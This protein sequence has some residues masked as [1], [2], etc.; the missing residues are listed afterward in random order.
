[1]KIL[2]IGG[3]ATGSILLS[4]LIPYMTNHALTL[5]DGDY[6]EEKNLLNQKYTAKDVGKNKAEV[7][8]SKYKKFY[9]EKDITFIPEYLTSLDQMKKI[10]PDIIIGC[11]DNV[12]TRK[13][14]HEYFMERSGNIVYID[15]G[16]GDIERNGQVVT[17]IKVNGAVLKPPVLDV[18]PEMRAIDDQI[19]LPSCE[20][21]IIEHPQHMTTNVFSAATIF[22]ILVNMLDFDIKPPHIARFSAEKILMG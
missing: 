10:R 16:N 2:Q 15:A 17:G 4:F 9:R 18:F 7:L 3:G 5:V 12:Y 22:G 20:R 8:I 19:S 6:V 14:L 13:I 1:M 21:T 11:V